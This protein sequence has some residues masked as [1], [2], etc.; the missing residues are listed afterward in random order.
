VKIISVKDYRLHGVKIIRFARFCDARGYFTETF[1]QSDFTEHP[2][3]DF[4]KNFQIVQINE[5]FS[6]SQTIRGLHFQW[7]PFM[8]KLVRTM[9]GRMVDLMLDIR[10]GS[11]TFGKATMHDMPAG[12][13]RD[14]N[15]WI[16]IPPGFA[17]GNYFAEESQIEY[18]CTG[19]YSQG[20][21]AGISPLAKDIDWSLADDFLKKE[22]DEI[23]RTSTLITEKDRHG[24][25]V[26]AWLNDNRSEHFI[27]GEC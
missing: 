13:D 1:R 8:G 5:S 9:C 23:A 7:N 15:E 24:L 2:E 3:M 6:R 4:M 18:F 16:W 21:E 20:C 25:T 26:N 17:H 27:Y 11:P 12:P 10:K 14:Y 22:F 19:Q